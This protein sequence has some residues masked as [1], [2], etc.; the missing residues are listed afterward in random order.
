MPH[1]WIV[2]FGHADYLVQK[3]MASTIHLQAANETK[4]HVKSLISD[5][6]FG[7]LEERN[8]FFGICVVYIKTTIYLSV[9]KSGRYLPILTST[10][11]NN[12]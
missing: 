2:L 11:V 1:K 3:W 5:H 7:I 12:F 9:S 10:S 8:L 6:F 4:L